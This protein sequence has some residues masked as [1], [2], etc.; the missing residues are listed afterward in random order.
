MSEFLKKVD[1]EGLGKDGLIIGLKL[2]EREMKMEGRFFALMSW[3]LREYFVVT[4]HLIKLKFLPQCKGLT[5][6]ES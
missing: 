1:K 6:A 3:K 4:E 2:K 5:M